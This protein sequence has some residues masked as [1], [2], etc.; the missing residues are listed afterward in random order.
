MDSFLVQHGAMLPGVVFLVIAAICQWTI[1]RVPNL[2]CYGFLGAALAIAGASSAG[3]IEAPGSLGSCFA[4]LLVGFLLF[5]PL[6][7]CGIWGAGCVK[8]QAVFG[9]WIGCAF[10]LGLTV[11]ATLAASLAATI[12]TLACARMAWEW[13]ESSQDDETTEFPAQVTLSA[14][15]LLGLLAFLLL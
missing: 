7:V 8:A 12:V 9:A 1:H 4:G 13:L 14:A 3:V 11:K 2:L 15:D 6:Y 10:P 5:L